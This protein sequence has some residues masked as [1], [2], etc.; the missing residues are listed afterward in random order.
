MTTIHANSTRDAVS[1]LEMLVGMANHELAMWFIHRQIA[2]SINVVVQCARLSGGVR[3]VVQVS[4]IT[5]TE[6]NVVMMHDLF[7][8]EQTGVDENKNAQGQFVA[9]GIRP[10]CLERLASSGFPLD[11]AMFE[12]RQLETS[13]LVP[14]AHAQAGKR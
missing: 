4:E 3:K 6:G 7:N 13:R 1:R 8:F 10:A 12:R 11:P 14:M 2:A 9:T 5:G